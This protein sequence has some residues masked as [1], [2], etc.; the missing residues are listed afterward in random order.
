MITGVAA[1]ISPISVGWRE[2]SG[3]MTF[4]TLAVALTFPNSH[5]FVERWRGALLLLSAAYLI[6]ILQRPS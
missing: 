5:G 1:I 3:V 2:V 6:M 4:G